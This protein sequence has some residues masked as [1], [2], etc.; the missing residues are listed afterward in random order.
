M[1][2]HL[3]DTL[4]RLTAIAATVMT[5]MAAL[6][7]F[8]PASAAPVQG[9]GYWQDTFS[10]ST[11]I[12]ASA[13]INISVS[14]GDVK[15][16]PNYVSS[17]AFNDSFEGT[18]INTSKWTNSGSLWATDTSQK[19]DGTYSARARNSGANPSTTTHTL[20]SVNINL[21]DATSAYLDFWYRMNIVSGGSCSLYYYN[22]TSYILIAS[23]TGANN[24]W[25]HFNQS[26]SLPTYKINNFQI[27]FV[28][29]MKR[30]NAGRDQ[31]W[32]DQLIVNKTVQQGYSTPGSLTSVSI[33]PSNLQSWG[34][35]NASDNTTFCLPYR[36]PI[37][38]LGTGT[39]LTD[40]QISIPV[41]YVSGKMNA[42]FSDLRFKDG[43]GNILSYWIESYVAS[44]SA[45]VWVK[46][47][48][49]AASGTTT[50]YMYYG[51]ATA[52]SASNGSNTFIFFDDFS[53]DLSKWTKETNGANINIVSGYLNCSGGSDVSPYG[54]TVLGSSASYTGFA[55]GIIEGKTYL[56]PN[57]IAEV[58][59]RGN[60]AANTGY[61]SRMDNRSAEGIGNLIWPY[62]VG[63]WAFIP[64][65][66]IALP[67]PVPSGV[68]YSFS[69]AVSGSSM[70]ISC[71]GQTLTVTNT[72]YTGPGEISLQNHFG[73]YV[74]FDDIR[75][76][77][78]ASPAPAINSGSEESGSYCGFTNPNT[79][80]SITYKIL[81]A[82][83][84][85]LL[86]T[87]TAAQ[88]AAGYD[89]SSCAVTASSIKL[90]AEFSTSNISQTP[91][92]YDWRVT[93]TSVAQ[94]WIDIQA[95][96]NIS[97]WDL[98][99]GTTN[100]T[101]GTLIVTVSSPGVTWLVTANDSDTVNTGGFMTLLNGSSYNSPLIHLAK[102][103]NVSAGSATNV[104]ENYSV[105][106]PIGGT[107]VKGTGNASPPI[108]FTQ[109]VTWDDSPGTYRIV[110]TF[111]A[112][113]E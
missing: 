64:P 15:L 95:P 33:T 65:G 108:T 57:S 75:V 112:T 5:L 17:V 102:A 71:A 63:G 32:V 110:V 51:S 103:M 29:S 86:C 35:F 113:V 54:H 58:G 53:G 47:P 46:V 72:T 23:L 88:A 67:P 106:L 18:N 61:K 48:S 78:Y 69:I 85:S 66:S 82:A 109:E 36:Q 26:I 70:G 77:K 6:M 11:G 60:Y 79:V 1:K 83:D 20:T 55:D 10:D 104:T 9:D 31:F 42:D 74:R 68:W 49:I 100:A 37:S 87:I 90:R 21:A 39:P 59:Y 2:A 96:I 92:L 7:P 40:Y 19:H 107:L 97:S 16:A 34:Q 76:R 81:N 93:W 94:D 4:L 105:T 73:A 43:S 14:G 8:A 3:T 38:I 101:V 22:G 98:Y 41:S 45:K 25:I 89:I 52:T 80:T 62:V 99:P 56:S 13:S 12:N 50:I 24:T 44:T 91:I 111:T 84:D 28:A 30:T 27:Q